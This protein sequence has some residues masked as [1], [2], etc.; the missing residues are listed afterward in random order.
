MTPQRMKPQYHGPSV[1]TLALA[2][3]TQ[4][5]ECATA[6][7]YI[8]SVYSWAGCICSLKHLCGLTWHYLCILEAVNKCHIYVNRNEI[9]V[10]PHQ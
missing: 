7:W 5:S 4:P 8:V 2:H 1:S 6:S 3:S 9:T 10:Y